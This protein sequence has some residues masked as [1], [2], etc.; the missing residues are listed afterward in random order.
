MKPGSI[1]L[2]WSQKRKPWNGTI[3]S[4]RNK[5]AKSL[6]HSTRSDH[7]LLGLWRSDSCRYDAER[8]YINS[9]AYIRTLTELRK[10][11]KGVWHHKTHQKSCFNMKT[12][13]PAQIWRLWKLS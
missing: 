3:L 11:F 2:N 6:H 9:E 8:G 12:Q 1:I 5:N 7:C 4:P 10:S 13:S